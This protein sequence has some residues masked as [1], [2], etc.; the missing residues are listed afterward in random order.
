MCPKYMLTM[1]FIV[2]EI[3]YLLKRHRK[4]RLELKFQYKCSTNL[5]TQKT[6]YY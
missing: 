4:L 3:T 2:H 5:I 6:V 1:R